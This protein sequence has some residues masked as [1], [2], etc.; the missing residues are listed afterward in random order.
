MNKKISLS[1]KT[2]GIINYGFFFLFMSLLM[3]EPVYADWFQAD[4][5]TDEMLKPVAQF[6]DGKMTSIILIIGFVG[7]FITPGQDLRQ[8]ATAFAIGSVAAAGSVYLAKMLLF[9]EAL[10][11]AQVMQTTVWYV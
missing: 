7:A 2:K 3:T 8:R 1:S 6:V 9:D 4:R 11:Q 5:I 10:L